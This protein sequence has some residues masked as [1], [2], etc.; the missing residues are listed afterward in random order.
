[1]TL[2]QIADEWFDK[3]VPYPIPDPDKL[4]GQCVQFIRWLLDNYYKLP[5]WGKLRGAADFW[6][7]YEK[8]PKMYKYFEKIPNTPELIPQEGDIFIQDHSKGGGYG[9][10]GVV[11]GDKNTVRQFF[12]VEQNYKPLKV[13]TVQH[14]YNA[15]LG[16]F[17]ARKEVI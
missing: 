7:S 4:Q 17:R 12:A 6:A 2:K 5:Q 15:C 1:M 14:N 9:H 16:F 3:T 8:D 11:I 10:I 13:S